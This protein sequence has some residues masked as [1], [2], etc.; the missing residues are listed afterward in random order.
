MPAWLQQPLK[1]VGFVALDEWI[2][3]IG[4]YFKSFLFWK[5]AL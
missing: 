2:S 1:G 3:P 5:I 4:N